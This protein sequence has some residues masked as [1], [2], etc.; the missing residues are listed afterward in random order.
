MQDDSG[1]PE[2]LCDSQPSETFTTS[3]GNVYNAQSFGAQWE[4]DSM[5]GPALPEVELV[6]YPKSL[7]VQLQRE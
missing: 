4:E 5:Q 7:L 3:M 1:S 6:V 2:E